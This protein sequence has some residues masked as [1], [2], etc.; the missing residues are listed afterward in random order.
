M[1]L[2][3]LLNIIF[4]RIPIIVL[5][6]IL[7]KLGNVYYRVY[8][9]GLAIC[10]CVLNF[11]TL[12]IRPPKP[13]D[14]PLERQCFT[15]QRLILGAVELYS[16][17][18][19]PMMTSLD[20]PLL[21]KEGYLKEEP[22]KPTPQCEYFSEGNL[23]IDGYI[24]CRN[25]GSLYLLDL[26]ASKEREELEKTLWYK[27]EKFFS[28]FDD[29]LAKAENSILGI[30]DIIDKVPLFGRPIAVI[31]IYF[32]MVVLG[33]TI[34]AITPLYLIA[35]VLSLFFVAYMFVKIKFEI[36]KNQKKFPGKVKR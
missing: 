17:D 24:C 21:L 1:H 6:I 8:V 20:M 36:I 23:V 22:K 34:Q 7:F 9:V 19:E 10:L 12:A 15:N 11:I 14:R 3:A 13:H 28:S 33:F 25:H 2:L 5:L 27:I 4:V 30:L 26:K 31:T 35:S 32:F 16:M 18:H 29:P